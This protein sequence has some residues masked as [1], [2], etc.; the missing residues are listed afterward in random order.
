MV[1]Y[2]DVDNRQNTKDREFYSIC[3]VDSEDLKG[4][5]EVPAAVCEEAAADF[6]NSAITGKG[7]CSMA[8]TSDT[9]EEFPVQHSEQ[10]E[11]E[12]S[13]QIELL[14]YKKEEGANTQ[15]TET[16]KY[17]SIDIQSPHENSIGGRSPVHRLDTGNTVTDGLEAEVCDEVIPKSCQEDTHT[18][19]AAVSC[20]KSLHRAC[21]PVK[22]VDAAEENQFDLNM[23]KPAHSDCISS[24]L[25][26][27]LW[28][29]KCPGALWHSWE[30]LNIAEMHKTLEENSDLH[31]QVKGCPEKTLAEVANCS[32][33]QDDVCVSLTEL[34]GDMPVETSSSSRTQSW[35]GAGTM[36]SHE[37]HH[38]C[39]GEVCLKEDS[40]KSHISQESQGNEVSKNSE[41]DD[42]HTL[43]S[44]SVEEKDMNCSQDEQQDSYSCHT[45]ANQWSVGTGSAKGDGAAAESLKGTKS[46]ALLNETIDE[47]GKVDQNLD[48][49]TDC[50]KNTLNCIRGLPRGHSI[51]SDSTAPVALDSCIHKSVQLVDDTKE[52]ED[53]RGLFCEAQTCFPS[54][55]QKSC[56][57]V[58]EK[59]VEE[60]ELCHCASPEPE[61]GN[62][63]VA[64]GSF[65]E[66]G[67][68]TCEKSDVNESSLQDAG[69]KQCISVHPEDE[70]L[71]GFRVSAGNMEAF[72][73]GNVK[74]VE[75][76]GTKLRTTCY[77]LSTQTNDL[78]TGLE[79]VPADHKIFSNKELGD[80]VDPQQVDKYAATP[81]YAI[82]SACRS[83]GWQRGA[84]GPM[85]DGAAGQEQQHTCEPDRHSPQVEGWP[86]LISLQ[87]VSADWTNPLFSNTVSAGNGDYLMGLLW[88]N[89]LPDSCV[90]NRLCAD[91][92]GFQRDPRA[93]TGASCA[94]GTY[95]CELLAFEP[96]GTWDWQ[97]TDMFV[98][99]LPK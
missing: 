42:K 31:T 64:V 62:T 60:P 96:G 79:Q 14:E 52:L 10:E 37:L 48:A 24:A 12:F 98:S 38:I 99:I 94:G 95:P 85:A 18:I 93:V 56:S 35:L 50:D 5:E 89:A 91:S 97:D 80:L 58:Q 6:D 44:V 59:P 15:E 25:L 77:G 7:M 33:M 73:T 9:G 13:S 49:N 68:E 53:A 34:R 17:C 54:Q 92:D 75:A 66:V 23:L 61:A 22:D 87:T 19:G 65:A 41:S 51:Y 27:A 21:D 88:N 16:N 4:D 30:A 82:H 28:K 57:H 45:V 47:M 63:Q 78:T 81:S 1:S 76:E 69:G 71:T 55:G 3:V 83:A 39:T 26:N 72:S 36:T 20:D 74:Q 8:Q 40:L 70:N 32:G 43:S 2:P 90:K 67:A 86:H 84:Q 46:E 29:E 11:A